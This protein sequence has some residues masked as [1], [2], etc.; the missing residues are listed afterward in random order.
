MS[1]VRDGGHFWGQQTFPAVW[2]FSA[3]KEFR[4]IRVS[5]VDIIDPTYSGIMFQTKYDGTTP[6]FPI[7]DT[8]CTNV[9]INGAQKSGDALDAKSGFGLWANEMPEAGQGPAVGSV[10]FNHLTFSNNFQNIKNTTSTFTITVN[11]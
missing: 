3:S 1:L 4:G 6:E 5:D 7:T 10:T 11:P 2:M 9:S 8:I